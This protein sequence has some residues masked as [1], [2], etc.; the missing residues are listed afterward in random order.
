MMHHKYSA[1]AAGGSVLGD[2]L[3]DSSGGHDVADEWTGFP[4][5]ESWVP[6][7]GNLDHDALRHAYRTVFGSIQG[8]LVLADITTPLRK[9]PAM[10]HS[11]AGIADARAFHDGQRALA[12][13]IV[14]MLANQT[15]EDVHG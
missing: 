1:N 4:G 8:K 6:E 3:L 9:V 10:N 2:F 12:L 13:R 5:T 15:V 11:L 14:R 7:R